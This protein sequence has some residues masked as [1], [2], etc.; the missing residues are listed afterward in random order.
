MKS[1]IIYK[2]GMGLLLFLCVLCSAV[3][4]IQTRRQFGLMDGM[5]EEYLALGYNMYQSGELRLSDDSKTTFVFRP[6]GYVKFIDLAFTWYGNIKPKNYR[7][8]SME[9]AEMERRRIFNVVYVCQSFLLAASALVLFLH[10][11]DVIKSA[12]AFFLSL[13]FGINPFVTIHVGLIHYELLHL[14]AILFSTWFLHLALCSDR[15]WMKWTWWALAGACWGGT[16]LI[17][18]VTLILPAVLALVLVGHFRNHWRKSATCWLLFVVSFMALL[19]PWTYR[20]WNAVNRF[21]PVN[22]QANVALWV[23]SNKVLELDANHFRWINV[24][25]PEGEEIYQSITGEKEFKTT[26]YADHVL[27]LED[28][29]KERFLENIV[30]KPDIYLS[31]VA[32]NFMLMTFGVNSVFIKMF[33]ELQHGEGDLNTQCLVPGASQDFYS[34]TASN[35]YAL[36]VVI[37]SLVG[38][39]GI[40]KACLVKDRRALA[41]LVSF[42]SL[43]LA[44]SITY[45]D[46][47]YYY[48]RVP[49]LFLFA[50]FFIRHSHLK[51][52]SR[53]ALVRRVFTLG[54]F[55]FSTCLYWLVIIS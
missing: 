42:A 55:A 51:T 12:S 53:H 2:T 5:A 39:W 4:S 37:L 20:N 8:F 15:K 14:F 27:A 10:L 45:T 11:S 23:S 22:A 26:T 17:R 29:F 3:Y 33:Q 54:P 44:H 46:I 49:F 50:A 25:R 1:A 41:A 7:F 52:S 32:K 31:N 40:I 34:S 13:A 47:M 24:W 48:T 21:I 35:S 30:K 6:P 18:P 19:F 36:Y 28:A 38:Y 16:T 43:I 9:E